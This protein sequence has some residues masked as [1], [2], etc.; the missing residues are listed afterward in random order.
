MYYA[1]YCQYGINISCFRPLIRGFFFYGL[2][3]PTI[4]N[5]D[6]N[7][8]FPSPH[9]GILFLLNVYFVPSVMKWTAVSV[10]SF[11]D[12]FFMRITAVGTYPTSLI[13][14]RPLIRG[15][16][17]YGGYDQPQLAYEDT[18]SVPSFGDSFFI[19]GTLITA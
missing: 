14:F 8:T 12:S 10:P 16:F 7:G 11:G 4:N 2:N 9:S 1:E 18:V 3:R 19:H 17:F 6:I 5:E 13:G 15:F